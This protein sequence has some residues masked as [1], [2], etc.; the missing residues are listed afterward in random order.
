MVST[1]Q[2]SLMTLVSTSLFSQLKIGE[3]DSIQQT[4]MKSVFR[5]SLR[6]AIL[7]DLELVIESSRAHSTSKEHHSD[8]L[9]SSVSCVIIYPFPHQSIIPTSSEWSPTYLFPACIWG[10]SSA[11]HNWILGWKMHIYWGCYSIWYTVS[12]LI[13]IKWAKK[14]SMKYQ[15][16]HQGFV[17]YLWKCMFSA[18]KVSLCPLCY[19]PESHS[20][21][22]QDRKRFVPLCFVKKLRKQYL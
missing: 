19:S 22:R 9:F 15:R 20:V 2:H 4:V 12:N 16:Y 5:W 11:A 8:R 6:R 18:V 13:K 7:F 21:M 1:S 3:N 10:Q 14:Y 17:S